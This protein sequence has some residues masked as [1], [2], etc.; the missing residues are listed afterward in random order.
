MPSSLLRT[1]CVDC[2]AQEAR[3]QL[4]GVHQFFCHQEWSYVTRNKP[5]TSGWA[6]ELQLLWVF[7]A[8]TR[9]PACGT[10]ST[11]ARCAGVLQQ[12]ASGLAKLSRM[13]D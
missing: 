10:H 1:Y 7:D 12:L 4:S 9:L 5:L 13:M 6:L 3:G 8:E 2:E 11:V